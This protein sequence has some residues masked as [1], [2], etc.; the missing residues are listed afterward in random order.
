MTDIDRHV[1]PYEHRGQ[2]NAGYLAQLLG[3]MSIEQL[4]SGTPPGRRGEHDDENGSRGSGRS[5][6]NERGLLDEGQGDR[7][8]LGPHRSEHSS[9]RDDDVREPTLD[10]QAAVWVKVS[11]ITGAMP[12][13]VHRRHS[14]RGPES[15]V[16]VADMGCPNRDLASDT[17]GRLEDDRWSTAG[18]E[19]RNFD[20]NPDNRMTDGHAVGLFR[21]RH[22]GQF[23]VRDR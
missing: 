12:A 13:R 23:D 17:V 2:V 15:V 4:R 3:A 20:I 21:D 22:A 1:A 19:R 9:R 7:P 11:D 10:P 6:T 18:I 5:D 14:V 16:V 8:L